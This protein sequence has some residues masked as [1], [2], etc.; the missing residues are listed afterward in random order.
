M[1]AQDGSG[2][3]N[4][5]VIEF[6]PLWREIQRAIPLEG[7][8]TEERDA[9]SGRSVSGEKCEGSETKFLCVVRL[10]DAPHVFH[11]HCRRPRRRFAAD[12]QAA[13]LVPGLARRAL[14]D[15]HQ[16]VAAKTMAG[17]REKC[18]EAGASYYL[19]RPVNTEQLLTTLRL[20]LHR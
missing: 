17:N 1:S 4:R 11:R 6:R 2:K 13:P 3:M 12:A 9:M 19:A 20:W 5:K 18:L 7:L 10:Q 14:G 15:A 16:S 8:V